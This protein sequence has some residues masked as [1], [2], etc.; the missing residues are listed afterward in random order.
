MAFISI[1]GGILASARGGEQAANSPRQLAI[2]QVIKAAARTELLANRDKKR[3]R[4]VEGYYNGLIVR[5]WQ[6]FQV[7]P[8][9]EHG[10]VTSHKA[11]SAITLENQCPNSVKR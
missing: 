5:T 4:G 8:I 11:F 6:G 7:G 9:L 1:A 2:R 3:S 10:H